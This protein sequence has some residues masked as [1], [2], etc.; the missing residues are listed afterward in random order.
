MALVLINEMVVKYDIIQYKMSYYQ[1][2]LA[3]FFIASLC[4]QKFLENIGHSQ[5]SKD[6][7]MAIPSILDQWN[8]S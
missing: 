4:I 8:T 2:N 3:L 7:N 1:I 6:I 5:H